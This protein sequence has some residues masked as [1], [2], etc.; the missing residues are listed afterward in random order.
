M[1][2]KEFEEFLKKSKLNKK[3]FSTLTELSYQTVMNWNNTDNVPKWVKSWLENYVKI[4]NYEEIR[5]KIYR[6]EGLYPIIHEHIFNNIHPDYKEAAVYVYGRTDSIDKTIK[7]VQIGSSIETDPLHFVKCSDTDIENIYN[8][9]KSI[10]FKP[11]EQ[12]KNRIIGC[13]NGK[14]WK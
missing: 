4:K 9:L 14:G 10:D 2:Y 8:Y 13:G 1:N 12:D 3:E 5:D 6:I 11:T 7:I